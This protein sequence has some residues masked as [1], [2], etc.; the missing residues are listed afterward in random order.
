MFMLLLAA[1]VFFSTNIKIRPDLQTQEQLGDSSPQQQ[2]LG[3]LEA[4]PFIATYIRDCGKQCAVVI[5]RKLGTILLK[6]IRRCIFVLSGTTC[7]W[8]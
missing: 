4:P 1:S 3:E 2:P 7:H 6:M 5:V 8:L